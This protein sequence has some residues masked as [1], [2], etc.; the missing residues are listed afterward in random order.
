[1]SSLNKLA[2]RGIRSF[3]D[4]NI[5]V[6]EFFSPVTVIVGH[7]GS[8]KTTIIECL[9]YVTT[10][11][12]PPNTRGGAFIHD[13]NMAN[14]K[15]V[16]A[17]VK[18]RFYAASGQRMLA[19]RNL[20]VTKKKNGL[21]MKTLEGILSAADVE[22]GKRGTISTKCAVMDSEMP[23]LLGV[24]KAVLENV[25]FCHQEDSYWPLAEASV[26]KK[27]FDDIFEATRYTKVLDSIKN[28]RKERMAEQK[29][30]KE[31]LESLSKEKANADKITKRLAEL[32]AQIAAKQAEYEEK[33]KQYQEVVIANARFK[34]Q[35]TH[36]RSV[37]MKLEQSEEKRTTVEA[38]LSEMRLTLK[39][40]S[41]TDEVLE[42]RLKNFDGQLAV[43]N[44]K[45]RQKKIALNDEEETIKDLRS[46]HIKLIGEQGT[47]QADQKVTHEENI[48]LR[49]SLIRQ[50]SLK[51]G[52]QGFS[53]APLSTER[54][55]E[56]Y[57]HLTDAQKK[58]NHDTKN[59]QVEEHSKNDELSKKL[60]DLRVAYNGLRLRKDN[61]RTQIAETQRKISKDDADLDA[62]QNLTTELQHLVTT[63]EEKKAKQKKLQETFESMDYNAK[64]EEKAKQC[65]EFED[66][67]DTLNSEVRS[68][69]IQSESRA[70]LHLK[71]SEIKSK[72]QDIK[73]IMLIQSGKIKSS[74]DTDSKP[75]TFEQDVDEA[76]TEK[77]GEYRIAE[78]GLNNVTK[79]L[80]IIEATISN[81]QQQ[82]S[83]KQTEL[84]AA[85]KKLKTEVDS[86]DSVQAAIDEAME[87]ISVRKDTTSAVA[88]S[89]KVYE[90]LLKQGRS[91]NL[92]TVCNRHLSDNE[93]IVFEKFVSLV[94]EVQ[95]SIR[96]SLQLKDQIK[97]TSQANVE[98]VN[99][100]L[101]EW[102]TELARLQELLPIETARDR[103]KNVE[104][105]ALE[106]Q[107][108]AQE[109][110]LPE[111]STA[112]EKANEKVA[113]IRRQQRELAILKQHAT[114][115]SRI[116]REIK[117]AKEEQATLETELAAT[118]STR[119][120]DDVQQEIEKLSVNIRT[121]ERDRSHITKE[122]DAALA[123]QRALEVEL[124]RHQMQEEKLHGRL[125]DR[126]TTEDRINSNRAL[127]VDLQN[128]MKEMDVQI[129]A[130]STPIQE[131]EEE[132][133]Q[134]QLASNEKIAEAQA[135][136]QEYNRSVDRID[137][138][139]KVIMDYEKKR[140]GRKLIEVIRQ[141]DDIESRIA[142]AQKGIEK[143]REECR[144]TE[145]EIDASG[146]TL[147]N[148]RE[149]ARFRKLTKELKHIID[150]IASLD[151]EEAAKAKRQF[152]TKWATAQEREQNLN[153]ESASLGGEISTMEKQL[154]SLRED[155]NE[156][157]GIT[158][159]YTD[160]LIKV[161][162]SDMANAD[163][164][165]YAKALDNAIMKYH[166]LKMEEINDT[167]RHLWNKTYQGTDI[168]GIKIV[169]D[170]EGGAT[171]RTYN[172]RVVMT[173]DQVEMDM[174]GRCSAG[175]KMLAS[176][177]IRLALADS[178]AQNCGILA[179][180]EPTN[181][182]DTENI[183]ALA[184][185][186]VE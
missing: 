175:Q 169:S 60:Q 168:D 9:K 108:I 40:V 162:M 154:G 102:E 167:M 72:T 62:T 63:M 113:E 143:A 55:A 7:N 3:D 101:K 30:E 77:E 33:K 104:I 147:A 128:Q 83:Q 95:N 159:K 153:R 37:Y 12:Q 98:D 133:R 156:Y 48:K 135:R 96:N 99:N 172:Y 86:A 120:I 109:A 71:Q 58:Q 34:D 10:G 69:N 57:T 18:L 176:I 21:T 79:R 25:I 97:K 160:Q 44:Q 179:L 89:S 151:I 127:L 141:T 93:M 73:N 107:K 90:S 166:S 142:D 16:K 22:K 41:D 132:Q 134:F 2:I 4:K 173:K 164:E 29:V 148:L 117:T 177:V 124:L 157:K 144:I 26:L 5:A 51:H 182:L 138:Q 114:T 88:G 181:A 8:G 139:N 28:L 161:K 103:L 165:K 53:D 129:S 61:V 82:L 81:I 170:N 23:N 32:S 131:L 38:E 183:D 112:V 94:F 80:Q 146:A 14:E 125:K 110:L 118:G 87:E 106:Q 137:Q 52:F 186:L 174:R 130:A 185:S 84:K 163:L 116:Q 140:L 66:H 70:K 145:R 100:E 149:N 126:Q 171:K 121:L 105:P 136:S 11:D 152:E 20:S 74:L 76:I 35:A 111:A 50:L 49:D 91:K 180:D 45:L 43:S 150:E 92:C 6:I 68:L 1:M 46:E 13:P 65:R 184:A 123:N 17:Q 19:V 24:S 59:L 178:F 56:F 36:F 85:E 31:R 122:R 75:E 15:E 78:E 115:V 47:L 158:K 54:V 119:S 42:Q 67:R 64:I 27:K 39:E 155:Q